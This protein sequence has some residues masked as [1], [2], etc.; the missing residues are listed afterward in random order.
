MMQIWHPGKA[1]TSKKGRVRTEMARLIISFAK[2]VF[3]VVS[4]PSE[5]SGESP[6]NDLQRKTTGY[7]TN[8]FIIN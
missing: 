4:L 5:T 6:R 1:K 3:P 2:G 8:I 7:I